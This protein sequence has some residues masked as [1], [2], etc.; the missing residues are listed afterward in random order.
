MKF[1]KIILFCVSSSPLPLLPSSSR[2]HP[3]R[4]LSA[5][6]APVRVMWLT[7][8]LVKSQTSSRSA[9]QRCST[10][11]TVLS[12]KHLFFFASRIPHSPGSHPICMKTLSQR[13]ALHTSP[14][15][16]CWGNPRLGSQIPS[17]PSPPL[18]FHLLLSLP[19]PSSLLGANAC[20]W[21]FFFSA[22]SF[23]LMALNTI[24]KHISR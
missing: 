12:R 11:W 10:S 3:V 23:D 15:V 18:H 22:Y 2:P 7:L 21:R 4:P 19:L 9:S 20:L 14:A 17:R 1:H 5:E 13:Q 24:L 16:R 6:K 8:F